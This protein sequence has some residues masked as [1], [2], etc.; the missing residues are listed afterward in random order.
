MA[1]RIQHAARRRAVAGRH[2]LTTRRHVDH[3]W[4]ARK[5]AGPT[6]STASSPS[7]AVGRDR[8]WG[9]DA[10]SWNLVNPALRW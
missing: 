10:C 7:P 5:Q 3:R 8:A 1:P 4:V 2:P 6:T 9:N